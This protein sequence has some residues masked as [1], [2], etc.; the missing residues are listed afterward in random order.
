MAPRRPPTTTMLAQ[1]AA[2]VF[3]CSNRLV[4]LLGEHPASETLKKQAVSYPAAWAT[5]SAS[6]AEA[7][8]LWSS[9]S[10]T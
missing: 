9:R 5:R 2:T 3:R 1:V 6:A 8:G 4:I 7:S 10:K